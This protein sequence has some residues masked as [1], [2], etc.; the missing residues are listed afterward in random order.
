MSPKAW[1][2]WSVVDAER[3]TDVDGEAID[4]APLEA[5]VRERR[6]ERLGGERELALG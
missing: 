2:T 5:S 1:A 6:L 4:V 3:P